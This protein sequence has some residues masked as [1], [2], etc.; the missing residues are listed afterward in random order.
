MKSEGTGKIAFEYRQTFIEEGVRL[1]IVVTELRKDEWSLS[2][3]NEIGVA[4]NWNEFFE[5]KD[6][7]IETALDA[8]REE[9]VKQFLNIEGFEYLQDDHHDV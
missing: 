1:E 2:V 8:I 7:A 9:G 4:S 3:V 6:R 5:S